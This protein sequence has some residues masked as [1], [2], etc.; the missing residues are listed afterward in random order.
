VP[1]LGNPTLKDWGACAFAHFA[2]VLWLSAAYAALAASQA[3]A[4]AFHR[5]ARLR[6]FL[7][8][9]RHMPQPLRLVYSGPGL[10]VHFDPDCLQ[11]NPELGALVADAIARWSLIESGLNRILVTLL[12]AQ[13]APSFAMFSALV[14]TRA[15]LEALNAAANTVLSGEDLEM[16]TAAY[17]IS[18]TQEKDRIKLA[19]WN[20]GH[21]PQ[22]PNALL[23]A[24]PD[25]LSEH[26]IRV[27]KQRANFKAIGT[28]D[29]P[30]DEL[31]SYFM[32]DL[33]QV[34]VYR[35][36]DLERIVRDFKETQEILNLVDFTLNPPEFG[37]TRDEIYHQLSNLRL[38]R[39]ALARIRG[40]A[41]VKSW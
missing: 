38:F 32:F 30:A 5:A 7:V 2:F 13:A 31:D 40:G 17:E 36:P 33:D 18:R 9:V 35:K 6:E 25:V 16:F 14:S 8:G 39:E 22:V 4:S 23:L 24:K 12:G 28:F 34:Y 26:Y 27:A 1:K 29:I 15:R 21:S 11:E 19:H 41:I 20:W 10:S 3:S 37:M